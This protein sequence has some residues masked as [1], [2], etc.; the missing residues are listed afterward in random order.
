MDVM[1]NV[2]IREESNRS[3]G[4]MSH[5]HSSF[6]FP[7]LSKE[8]RTENTLQTSQY[9]QFLSPT[10]RNFHLPN[11]KKTH[12]LAL[13]SPSAALARMFP[14]P[15]PS[16]SV[17]PA[18]RPVPRHGPRRLRGWPRPTAPRPPAPPPRSRRPSR[19]SRRPSRNPPPLRRAGAASVLNGSRPGSPVFYPGPVKWKMA[20]GKWKRKNRCFRMVIRLWSYSGCYAMGAKCSWRNISKQSPIV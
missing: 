7:T 4:R 13:Q 12:S 3:V 18:A 16:P 17:R 6:I 19:P 20:A 8:H 2:A 11:E 10:W 15:A 5:L 14:P 9:L 1:W